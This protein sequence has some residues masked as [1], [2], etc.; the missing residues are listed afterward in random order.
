M[1]SYLQFKGKQEL[2]FKN[3]SGIHVRTRS[4]L[5]SWHIIHSCQ[6]ASVEGGRESDCICRHLKGISQK[7]F[8]FMPN[9]I[10]S[11]F[12]HFIFYLGSELKTLNQVG[13]A[14]FEVFKK[15]KTLLDWGRKLCSQLLLWACHPN[16]PFQLPCLSP[17]LKPESQPSQWG[18]YS[19]SGAAK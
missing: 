11:F 1:R 8:A 2:N 7:G 9:K 5:N 19:P 15:A 10:S 17:S 13:K 4:L 16:L 14:R 18:Q 12:P 6:W 3:V